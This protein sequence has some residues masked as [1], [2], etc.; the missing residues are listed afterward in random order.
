[1]GT[2]CASTYANI[3]MAEFEGK[4][5]YSFIK[6][7]LLLYLRS[8]VYILMIWAKLENEPKNWKHLKTKHPSIKLSFKYSKDKIDFLD[9]LVYKDQHQKMWSM[10]YQKP[11]LSRLLTCKHYRRLIF[12]KVFLI[13]RPSK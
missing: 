10:K 5:I 7:I 11:S 12:K 13:P 6:Q 4:Y 1:M 3:F 8:T 9:T 2:R